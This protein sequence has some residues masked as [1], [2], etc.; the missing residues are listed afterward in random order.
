MKKTVKRLTLALLLTA[1]VLGALG[2]KPARVAEKPVSALYF[3]NWNIYADPTQQVK[4]LPWQY[5]DC[6][7]HAFWHVVPKDGG[8]AI[9]SIDPW[10]DTDESNPL[11]HFRQ[12]R[13]MAARYPDARILLSIGGWTC[14]GHFSEMAL[15]E[16]SRASFIQSCLDTLDEYPFFSGLDLDW[17]YPGVPRAVGVG[18]EGCPVA[19]D[20]WN[21]YTALLKELRAALDD[22]FGKGNKQL[23]VCAGAP[24][25]VLRQQDYAMLHKYVDAINVMTYDMVGD[26]AAFTG[27]HAALYG[28]ASADTAV[29]YLLSQGVPVGKLRIGCPLYSRGWRMAEGYADPVGAPVLQVVDSVLW[30]DLK[31]LE[32]APGWHAEYDADARA[33][34]LWNDDPASPDDRVFYSYDSERSL[35]D[36]LTYIQEKGLGGLILWESGGDSADHEMLKRISDAFR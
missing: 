13:E 16:E 31:R 32:T 25:P 28:E 26:D 36:K 35:E 4:N 34:Y 1:P 2:A 20:D 22:H 29:K 27:H 6:I 12:Y 5:A 21:N 30:H 9:E 7:Y 8:F 33:A 17:E 19:G 10:A 11:P 14:C 18:G 23:T 3:P 24:L 15:T